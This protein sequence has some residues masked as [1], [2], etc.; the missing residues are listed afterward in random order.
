MSLTGKM[1]CA[2]N[3]ELSTKVLSGSFLLLSSD[4]RMTSLVLGLLLSIDLRMT[5]RILG[6]AVSIDIRMMSLIL[7]ME[8]S[9]HAWKIPFI[10]SLPVS[11]H[12]RMGSPVLTLSFP[13][14]CRLHGCMTFAIASL[15]LA[16]LEASHSFMVRV[17][18][19]TTLGES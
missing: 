8:L 11:D 12:V 3:E 5:L 16:C 10:L 14:M 18:G 15:P 4:I 1:S 13:C 2:S 6:L 17:S 19:C 7:G 9:T